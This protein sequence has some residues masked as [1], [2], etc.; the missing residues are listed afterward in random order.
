M[1]RRATT[2]FAGAVPCCVCGGRGRSGGPGPV[3]GFVS[4]PFR[5]SRPA[6]PALRVAGC[7]VRVS[8]TPACW[9]A[10]PCGLCIPRAWSGCPSGFPRVSFACVCAHD[11]AASA[12]FLPPQVGVVRAPRAVPVQAAGRAAPCGP[13]PSAFL[14]SAPCAVCLAFGGGGAARSGSPL[15]WLRVVCPLTGGSVR[16]GRSGAGGA[17]GGGAACVP[18]PQEAWPGCS[19]GR[20]IAVPWSVPLPSLGGH[21]SGCYRRRSVPGGRGLHTAPVRFRALT[22]G[23]VRVAPLCAD[24][25]PPACRGLCGSRQ[26]AAW[27]RVAYWLSRVPPPGAAALSGGG[28]TSSGLGKGLRAGAPVAHL[29]HPAGLRGGNGGRAGGG[30]A[31]W[32]LATLLSGVGL[33][34]PALVPPHGR[35]RGATHPSLPHARPGLFGSP[36]RRARSRRPLVGQSG[37]G[38]GVFGA[39]PLIGGSAGG[40]RGAGG[41][42]VTL[43]RYVSPPTPGGHEGGLLRHCSALHAAQAHVRAPMMRPAEC[44]C[45]PAQGCRPAAGTAGVVGRLTGGT[46]RTAAR[47]AAA[48][49]PGCRGPLG[50][51][52]LPPSPAGGV[53]G[54]HPPG[55]PPAVRGSGVGGREG[56]RGGALPAVPLWSPGAASCWLRGGGLVVPAPGGQPLTGGGRSPLQLPCTLRA[57]GRRAGP[58]PQAP[59]SPCCCRLGAWYRWGR[60][61]GWVPSFPEASSGGPQGRGVALPRSV[62]LSSLE[63]PQSG[64]Y[65]RRSVH[66]RRG[67]HTAL[68]RVR[69]LTPG[70]VRALVR[71]RGSAC[72]SR[73]LWEQAGRG[74]GARGVLA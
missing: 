7:P 45:A 8:L 3:P 64:S 44:P 56:R 55:R 67:L 42:G 43:P 34:P 19:E 59:R 26:V 2:A 50:G 57:L 68:V 61:G 32:F 60:G 49:P 38:G 73:S 53:R 54:R 40:A 18:F 33:R 70:V 71:W 47:T 1:A 12:P 28:V 20:G 62:P 37:R 41:G 17:W 36:G 27:G 39:P 72:L 63:G 35:R 6:F 30:F 22:P 25:G 11:L 65:R 23:V 58:D 48:A 31:P 51:G 66:G 5:T 29:R 52:V 21:Q 69:V 74:V 10:T 9:Y 16:P 13:C 14:A 4:F 15:A 24:A 46:R